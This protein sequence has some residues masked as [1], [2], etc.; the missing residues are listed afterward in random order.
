MEKL[1]MARAQ[2][3]LVATTTEK[4]LFEHAIAVSACMGAMAEHFGADRAYWQAVGY[5]HDY[6]FEQYPDEHLDH[7]EEPLRQ[8]GVD[9]ESIRAILAH[10]YTLRNTVEP[11]TDMEKSLFTVDELSGLI[12]ATAK[13]RPGGITDLEASSVKKKF[14]DK[15]FAAKIDRALI[16]KGCEMLGM[17]LPE[18]ITVCISGMREHAG[19]LGIGP[20]ETD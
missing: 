3:L 7:T 20:R 4:H 6:D 5:L 1:T 18:V 16:L 15:R 14:K 19:E 11:V 17:E 8:A 10:G 13:M 9:E 2:E 12:A